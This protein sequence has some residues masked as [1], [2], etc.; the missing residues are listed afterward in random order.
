MRALDLLGAEVEERVFL[1]MHVAVVPGDVHMV[2]VVSQPDAVPHMS[3]VA[4]FIE[5]AFKLGRRALDGHAVDA[6]TVTQKLERLRV[7]VAHRSSLNQGAV[8][9]M[10]L[11]SFLIVGAMVDDPLVEVKLYLVI[12]GVFG[13]A[14]DDVANG[15]LDVLLRL[16]QRVALEGEA[17]GDLQTLAVGRVLVA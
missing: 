13:R 8:Y 2:P 16:L 17:Q 11:R 1:D 4:A 9:R 7:A 10:P 12:G 3:V 15:F 5:S 6:H 14:L